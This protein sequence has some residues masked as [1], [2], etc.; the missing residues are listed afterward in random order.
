MSI[1]SLNME[2][3]VVIIIK[4]C[5]L[6]NGLVGHQ[7]LLNTKQ[8]CYSLH[9]LTHKWQKLNQLFIKGCLESTLNFNIQKINYNIV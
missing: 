3:L 9:I 2:Q 5:Q 1:L 7:Y 6:N 4:F 8:M